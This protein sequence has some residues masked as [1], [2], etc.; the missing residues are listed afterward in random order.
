MLCAILL[1]QILEMCRSDTVLLRAFSGPRSCNCQPWRFK[2][3]AQVHAQPRS[4]FSNIYPIQMFP[5]ARSVQERR[6]SRVRQ[7]GNRSVR[8]ICSPYSPLAGVAVLPLKVGP[9]A[10]MIQ[11]ILAAQRSCPRLTPSHRSISVITDEHLSLGA[12]PCFYSLMYASFRPVVHKKLSLRCTMRWRETRMSVYPPFG[13]QI[14]ASMQLSSKRTRATVIENKTN[15]RK[16]LIGTRDVT[17]P[18][19]GLPKSSLPLVGE[20]AV[21]LMGAVKPHKHQSPKC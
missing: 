11:Y 1:Y 4:Q 2:Q 18:Y 20:I 15:S 5:K 17:D 16:Q 9:T 19:R 21:P 13:R 8:E 3:L 6:S 12:Q 7:G 10:T 14:E